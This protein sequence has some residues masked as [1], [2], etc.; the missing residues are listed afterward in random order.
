MCTQHDNIAVSMQ[1]FRTP[2]PPAHLHASAVIIMCVLSMLWMKLGGKALRCLALSHTQL[3]G[4]SLET[5]CWVQQQFQTAGKSA[6]DYGHPCRHAWVSLPLA[7]HL[8]Y[9]RCHCH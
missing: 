5:T 6:Y 7:D 3:S 2:Q 9:S 4:E 1:V 8:T